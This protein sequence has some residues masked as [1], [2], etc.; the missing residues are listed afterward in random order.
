MRLAILVKKRGD[1][2]NLLG[3]QSVKKFVKFLKISVKSIS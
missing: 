2:I 3:K 1:V